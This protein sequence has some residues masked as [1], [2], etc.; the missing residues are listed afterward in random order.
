VRA[1]KPEAWIAS[2]AARGH[3]IDTETPLPESSRADEALLMG[4][5]LTAGIDVDHFEARTGCSLWETVDAGA[6]AELERLGLVERSATTLRLTSA[7]QPLL[8]AVLAKL[9]R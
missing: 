8:N 2:V 7:G 5:R 4:L 1:T 9:V 3:G 6:L